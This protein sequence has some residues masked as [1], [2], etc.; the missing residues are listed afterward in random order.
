MAGR[1]KEREQF[2]ARLSLL[3]GCALLGM[4]LGGVASR[5][6]LHLRL[7]TPPKPGQAV[8]TPVPSP[9]RVGTTDPLPDLGPAIP[10]PDGGPRQG[11]EL[12]VLVVDPAGQ[13]VEGVSV[14]ARPGL[15]TASSPT[16]AA[17]M[18]EL[19]VLPGALPFPEDVI[20]GQTA[21]AGRLMRGGSTTSSWVATSDAKGVVHFGAVASGRLLLLANYQG[22]SASGEVEVPGATA[23]TSAEAAVR[24]VLRLA[25][26]V[27]CIESVVGEPGDPLLAGT[28]LS[29]RADL[30]GQVVDHR[31]FAVATAKVE[32]IVAGTRSQTTSDARGQFVLSM[33][34]AGEARLTVRATG[35]APL[36]QSV[37]PEQRR[38]ELK[39]ELRP[40]G[41]LAGLIEDVR[42]SG[43]PEGLEVWLELPSG[44]R[45]PLPVG[46]DGHF[47]QTGLPPGPVV[48][49][50]RARG[51]AA[52]RQVVQVPDGSSPDQVT[53]RD[54]R[55][56]FARGAQLSGQVRG[57]SGNVEG[58]D[59]QVL[60]D[61]GQL[62]ARA[63]SDRRGEFDLQDLPPGHLRVTA[64]HPQGTATLAIDLRPSDRQHQDLELH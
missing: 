24:V 63:R 45:W 28:A 43:L 9:P 16:G 41:G 51:Y 30:R 61:D 29:A 20:A 62:V 47:T 12:W 35:F 50:A 7:R 31:G 60:T 4:V 46:P 27:E 59:L 14:L 6:P 52:L 53:V 39:L 25:S 44:E 58:A 32:V 10:M 2:Y 57:P 49:R 3:L 22:K 26:P 64:T 56:H 33:L 18:G 8:A 15:L 55:L 48:V 37:R 5:L 23:A 38:E 11:R 36:Q 42:T 21:A 54:V 40:G 13:P 17:S 34:P 19:G 1:P